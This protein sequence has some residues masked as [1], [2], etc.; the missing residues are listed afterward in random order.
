M[1]TTLP[2][3]W[4]WPKLPDVALRSNGNNVRSTMVSVLKTEAEEI[5][6]LFTV[7]WVVIV[8]SFVVF[9]ASINE[10]AKK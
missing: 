4:R 1:C 7:F 8:F 3:N 10:N 2:M 9:D 5:S 6:I